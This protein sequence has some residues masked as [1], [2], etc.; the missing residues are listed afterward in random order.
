MN[1]IIIAGIG[2]Y[3]VGE[4]W[5]ISLRKM[6]ARAVRAAIADSGGLQ[7]QG[8]FVGNAFASIL[9]HQS[10]LAALIAD[11]AGLTGVEACA[12]EAAGA[13]G[14]AAVRAPGQRPQGRA[15]SAPEPQARIKIAKVTEKAYSPAP[16]G[17]PRRFRRQAP[18]PN[19]SETSCNEQDENRGYHRPRLQH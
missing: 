18:A 9:S 7:P 8:L 12:F 10:N 17:T 1:D 11:E 15:G 13:S 19:K 14:G 2:L 6:G 4:H 5:D 3:P 16:Q